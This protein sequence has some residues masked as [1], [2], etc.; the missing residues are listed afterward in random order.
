MTERKAG[1][2]GA[3]ES[4]EPRLMLSMFRD[5]APTGYQEW[6]GTHGIVENGLDGND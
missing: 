6:D 3:R 5:P 2:R 4:H 1:K